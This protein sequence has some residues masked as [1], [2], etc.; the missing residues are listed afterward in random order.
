LYIKDDGRIPPHRSTYREDDDSEDDD[1]NRLL[2]GRSLHQHTAHTH[3]SYAF[4]EFEDPRD[5]AVSVI[6]I[7]AMA[8]ER[9][10]L[11]FATS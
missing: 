8:D 10:T 1:D 3:D 9:Q 7:Y 6:E 5:A 4:I 2:I 11:T